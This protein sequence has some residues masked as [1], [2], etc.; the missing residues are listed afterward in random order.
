M[1]NNHEPAGKMNPVMF[2]VSVL[3]VATAA[4]VDVRL[5]Q[6]HYFSTHTHTRHNVLT[7]QHDYADSQRSNL[8][9]HGNS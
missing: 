8:R 4:C 3:R 7:Q 2:L 9:I 5:V 6:R 1:I